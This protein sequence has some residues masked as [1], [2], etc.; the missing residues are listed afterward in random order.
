MI[1]PNFAIYIYITTVHLFFESNCIGLINNKIARN[2][3]ASKAHLSMLLICNTK[4]C[5]NTCSLVMNI[6][7]WADG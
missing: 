7:G 2:G 6:V 3:R 1:L 5:S 4:V